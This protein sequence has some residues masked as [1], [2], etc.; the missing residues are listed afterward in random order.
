MYRWSDG[1]AFLR[2]IGSETLHNGVL[3]YKVR[4]PLDLGKLE[5][6]PDGLYTLE[7]IL[8]SH[9]RP[10]TGTVTFQVRSVH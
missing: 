7:G 6:Y 8:T 5:P 3:K 9:D 1:R 2:V 4:I 10:T